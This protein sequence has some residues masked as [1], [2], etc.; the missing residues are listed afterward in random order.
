VVDVPRWWR[1]AGAA[2]DIPL[3]GSGPPESVPAGG[4]GGGGEAAAAWLGAQSDLVVVTD[5]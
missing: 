4:D 1:R 3:W 5:R 2:A